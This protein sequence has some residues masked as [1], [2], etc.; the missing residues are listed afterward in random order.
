VSPSKN[1]NEQAK[2]WFNCVEEIVFTDDD[3]CND[4]LNNQDTLLLSP[5]Q[6]ISKI[7]ALQ[8]A[9][10]VCLYQGWE[11]TEANKRRI[12]RYRFSTVISVR[13]PASLGLIN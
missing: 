3:F 2:I 7:Q 6:N 4:P 10:M 1:D 12:R 9:Y 5:I 11:G 8:A 13:Y